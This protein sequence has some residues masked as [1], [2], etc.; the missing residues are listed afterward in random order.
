MLIDQLRAPTEVPSGKTI[1]DLPLQAPSLT[2]RPP[3]PPVVCC[4]HPRAKWCARSAA[5]VRTH[6][7]RPDKG[8]TAAAT[9]PGTLAAHLSQRREVSGGVG[10]DRGEGLVASII[11]T[12]G[13]VQEAGCSRYLF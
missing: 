11:R 6:H 2:A 3:L 5:D 10:V 7:T 1:Q 13:W 12:S 8:P 4:L 9:L